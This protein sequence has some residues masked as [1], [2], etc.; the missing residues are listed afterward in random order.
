MRYPAHRGCSIPLQRQVL[1]GGHAVH[2]V[3]CRSCLSV[4]LGGDCPRSE[5]VRLLGDAD[6]HRAGAGGL[7][8]HLEKGRAGLEQAGEERGLMPVTAA[9]TDLE[10][11]KDRPVVAGLLAWNANAV[12][13]AKFDREELSVY[14]ARESIREACAQLKAQ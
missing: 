7:L 10:Q 12:K 1:H 2:P 11:L 6:L 14:I 8:L 9:V 5:D 13:G 4:S 3:R